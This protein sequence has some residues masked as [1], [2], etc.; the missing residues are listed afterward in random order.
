MSKTYAV[1]AGDAD[2]VAAGGVEDPLRLGR[3][4]GGVE[5]VE[6]V[7]ALHPLRFAVGRLPRHDVVP[8]DVPARPRI[9][10]S[11]PVRRTT[12]TCSIVGVC[13]S[14]SSTLTFRPAGLPRR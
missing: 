14:A 3:R 6:H 4:P 9:V 7:L 5:Q 10:T 12:R 8:P 2:E 13:C 11:C 1:G